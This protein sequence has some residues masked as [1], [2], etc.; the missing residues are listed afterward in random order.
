MQPSIFARGTWMK[1]TKVNG[2]WH[3]MG[4]D[5]GRSRFYLPSKYSKAYTGFCPNNVKKWHPRFINMK[6]PPMVAL[7]CS[8]RAGAMLE[9]IKYRNNVIECDTA[10]ER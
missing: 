5:R 8:T 6:R 4:V 7:F 2:R 3:C 1:P 9:Q 10:T